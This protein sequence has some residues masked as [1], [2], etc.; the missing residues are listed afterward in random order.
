MLNI[1]SPDPSEGLNIYSKH[2]LGTI[3][4]LLVNIVSKNNYKAHLNTLLYKF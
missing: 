2:N 3:S 1:Q 4:H